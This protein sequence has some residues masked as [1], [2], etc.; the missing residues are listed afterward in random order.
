MDVG[1][2]L[3]RGCGKLDVE[4]GLAS[5]RARVGAWLNRVSDSAGYI[6]GIVSEVSSALEISSCAARYYGRA[7]RLRGAARIA[8][9]GAHIISGEQAAAPRRS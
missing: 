4:A 7:W 3:A 6:L 8:P 9:V 2:G 1:D 5:I